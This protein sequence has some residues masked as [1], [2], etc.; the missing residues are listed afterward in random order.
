[1]RAAEQ[2]ALVTGGNRGIGLETCR[3]L[4]TRG[5][6]VLLASRDP[7]RGAAAV[8]ALARDGLTLVQCT[9]DVTQPEDIKLALEF[10]QST[11]GRLDVLVN[12]AGVYLDEQT[13]I[14]DLS[15]TDFRLTM[16][17]NFYGPLSLCRAF[18]PLMR[19]QRYGRIV[20][21]SSGYGALSEMGAGAPAYSISKAA[22]NALTCVLAD[23]LRGG[24]IK[25]NA[26][27]P[28][29]VHTDMGGPAA[30]RT[31]AEGAD[32]IVWLAT[33]PARGPS[34]GFFRDRR[35]IAW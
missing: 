5:V 32:T 34:G 9:L 12:N 16:E 4:A 7:D 33:L 23:E 21:V 31:P 24:D 17:T 6:N 27:C 10:V 14:L 8:E 35:R 30:P 26:A 15:Q 22:L 2:F 20:N 25:V 19:R 1:V 11:C 29:W 13:S 28:G 3:Q 18:A